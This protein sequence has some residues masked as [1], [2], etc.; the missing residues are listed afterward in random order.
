KVALGGP[1]GGP[2]SIG[3]DWYTGNTEVDNLNFVSFSSLPP[4]GGL[5]DSDCSSS[6]STVTGTWDTGMSSNEVFDCSGFE[7]ANN[8]LDGP[9]VSYAT[10]A[11]PD[12]THPIGPH[13]FSA[14]SSK[15]VVDGDD[16]W[17]LVAG[18]VLPGLPVAPA[19][20]KAKVTMAKSVAKVVSSKTGKLLRSV[21]TH[22]Q[23]TTTLVRKAAAGKVI[24]LATVLVDNVGPTI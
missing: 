6:T 3:G 20:A 2:A 19:L 17:N 21:R 24:T 23:R 14:V 5:L 15:F 22:A 8:V 9:F 16:R 10:N 12:A 7:G 4:A 1:P 13:G 11:G 18:D